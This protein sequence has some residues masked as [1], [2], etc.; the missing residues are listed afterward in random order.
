MTSGPNAIEE[1]SKINAKEAKGA[2]SKVN[3]QRVVLS[4]L[5]QDELPKRKWWKAMGCK[6]PEGQKELFN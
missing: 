5:K 2:E 6:T 1:E 4:E 3:N